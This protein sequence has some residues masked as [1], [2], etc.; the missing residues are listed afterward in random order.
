MASLPRYSFLD[1][2]EN[3]FSKSILLAV[4]N[5]PHYVNHLGI[6]FHKTELIEYEAD[7]TGLERLERDITHYFVKK[8]VLPYLLGLP[9]ARFGRANKGSPACNGV[10]NSNATWP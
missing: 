1:D 3:V 8:T 6:L 9:M 2:G 10:L 7:P 4:G 5:G